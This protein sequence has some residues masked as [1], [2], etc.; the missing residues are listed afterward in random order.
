MT[1]EPGGW[2]ARQRAREHELLTQ[3]AALPPDDPARAV[4]RDEL[5]VLH[6]PL[7]RYLARRYQSRGVPSEDVVQ[8]GVIGLIKAI[9]RYDPD[10]GVA[11]S[12][13]ATPTIVGEIKRHF[14]DH[15]WAV[16]VPR[17]LQ[18]RA[19]QV[20]RR[21]DELTARTGKVP[22]VGELATDLGLTDDDVLE[23]LEARHAYAAEGFDPV[24][25]AHTSSFGAVDVEFEAV[26]DREALRPL[27][28][29][30]PDRERHILSLRFVDQ[31]SQSQIADRLGISQMHVSRLLARTLAELRVG[32]TA[33]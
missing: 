16:R 10:R 4:A 3:L 11:L 2:S 32:L 22:T 31:L 20:G 17:A 1:A 21:T 13:F 7:V 12:T 8:V 19:L 18:D 24:D 25:D 6:L 33:D 30:L 5:V 23:A 15:T 14:R 26:E 28:A 9:D 29:A 27:L